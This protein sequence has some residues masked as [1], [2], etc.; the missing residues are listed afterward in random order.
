MTVGSSDY[1]SNTASIVLLFL[2]V[3]G[4]S[5]TLAK[6]F[7]VSFVVNVLKIFGFIPG[8][9]LHTLISIRDDRAS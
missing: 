7:V 6:E 5:F 3:I 9:I 1:L 2:E 4:G 8:Y